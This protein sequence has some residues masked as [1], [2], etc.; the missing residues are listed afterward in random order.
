VSRVGWLDC[1]SG[2]SGDMLLGC[3]AD[4][5]ALDGLTE[6]LQSLPE[7]GAAVE[8]ATE[9]R[10]GLRATR[11]TVSPGE[12]GPDGSRRRLA[13]VL[14]LVR[15][16]EV[17]APVRDRATST[18]R[19]LAAA[20]AAVHGLAVEDMH[21]H[22]VGAAD[23]IVD[24]LGTCLGLHRLALDALTVGTVSLGGGTT[25]S[26]H[27]QL[28]V[29]APAVLELLRGSGFV[30]APGPVDVELATPTGVAL[31]AEWAK[32]GAA[33]PMTVDA[34]G[35]G[36]GG[37]DLAGHPNVVRLVVGTPAGTQ[38]RAADD[39]WVIVE[40]NVDDLDPRLW[41]EVLDGLLRAGAA[42]AWLTPILMKKGRP[43]HTVSA[44]TSAN[45]AAAIRT[46]LFRTSSTLGVRTTRVSKDT[47]QRH[48]V[49][50]DVD[51][52]RIRVKFATMDGAVV[53]AS[54]EWEDVATAARILERPAKL[55]MAAAVAA[56]H[57][58]LP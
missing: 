2:V 35:V 6:A 4:L 8:T 47:L 30:T 36:A 42:D 38:Q 57:R 50:V 13:D 41:P 19:R 22:E 23:A 40:A 52:Q 16:A 12:T 43:A 49:D 28:P 31:L 24:V 20:E 1:A 7:L 15:R 39:E 29:P 54:P 5:G 44:L 27:E 37:R 34:V 32:P 21:F 53:N 17:P 25:H 26:S 58:D 10:A 3:L 9:Q 18:F 33:V 48:W 46:V 11:V 45:A 51:G 55:V 14:H 56:A